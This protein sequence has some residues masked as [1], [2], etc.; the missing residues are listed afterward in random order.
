MDYEKDEET[1]RRATFEVIWLTMKIYGSAYAIAFCIYVTIR[2]RFPSTYNFCNS[3]EK[4]KNALAVDHHGHFKWIWKNLKHSDDE[5]LENCGLTAAVLLRFLKLGL[6]IA[7]I[8]IFNSFFL[9]PVNI[10]GCNDETDV[11]ND[12]LDGVER[13]GLGNLS[14]GSLSFLATTVAAYIMFGST[15]YFIYYEF[16]WFT[17]ARHKFLSQPRPDNYSV[18]VAHIPP[19]FRGDIALLHYF[20]EVFDPEDVLEAKIALDI[21]NLERKVANRENVVQQLE[22]RLLLCFSL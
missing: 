4:Y 22:V 16:Q 13:I 14:N 15:M 18:Y 3:V 8:G 19:R 1:E 21:Y 5:I 2:P 12:I 9:I 10:Y 20:K 11:C 17:G 6:K 7:L